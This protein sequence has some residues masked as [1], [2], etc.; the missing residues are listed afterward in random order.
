MRGFLW[1]HGSLKKGKSRVVWEVV[2]L[3]R[4]EGGLGIRRLEVFN[5]ALMIAHVWKLISLKESLW[6]K[7]VHEYK[8][9]GRSFWEIPLR[10]NESWG[11]MKILQLR[12]IIR[13]FIWYDIGDGT[14]TS[15]WF[16]KWCELGP[17]SN[18]ISSHDIF[19]A[20]LTLTSKVRDV[21][22]EGTWSW[23]QDLLFK[24]PFFT[25]CQVPIVNSRFDGL[26]WGTSHGVSKPFS[27]AQV[28]SDIRPRGTQV[29]WYHVVW[30]ASC[31]P[32]HA[33]NLWLVVRRKLKMGAWI[34]A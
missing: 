24:Y 13:N 3:L 27:I 26:L 10:G 20:G 8:L 25:A 12:P 21:Y 14:A 16:D 15:L 6:V 32:R 31:I 5:S 2:C 1:C 29:D 7:W 28:W 4:K 22:H 23:P 9:K 19:K 17:L 30:F 11:W 33:F 34:M 18:S